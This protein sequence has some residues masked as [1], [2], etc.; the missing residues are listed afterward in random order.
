MADLR[1]AEE[2]ERIRA[3]PPKERD[4]VKKANSK[5]T[6]TTVPDLRRTLCPLL[7][8]LLRARAGRE[9][10]EKGDAAM[11][12]SDAGYEDDEEEVDLS[13]YERADGFADD[14]DEEE[15]RRPNLGDLS[16]ED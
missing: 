11:L 13:Q 1:K 6:G 7:T 14:E 10:F 5:L 4:E 2:A 3:L 9:Q 16:D 8:R 12:A 15:K